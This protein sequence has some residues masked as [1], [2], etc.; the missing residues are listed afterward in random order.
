MSGF[1]HLHTHSHYSLLDGAATVGALVDAAVRNKMAALA[2]T[3]HGNMFGAIEFY[4]ACIAAGIKPLIGYE[5]YVAPGSRLEKSALENEST[6]YHLTLLVRDMEGYRNLV[7][8]ASE[9]Y[10]T[11]FYYKPRIDNE[12][13]RAHSGGLI[14]L[15]GCAMSRIS[16]CIMR[17]DIDGA[18]RVA[19]EYT[20]IFGD[21]NFY[22]ELQD[23]GIT[24]LMKIRE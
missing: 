3:D 16:A 23:H 24:E 6:S 17:D 18:E 7:K 4:R 12:L 8:L 15:S 20:E 1:V 21:G 14:A 10:L 19:R 22:L 11:G 13:L 2:L 5:A 9:A